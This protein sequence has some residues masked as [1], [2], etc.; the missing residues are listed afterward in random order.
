MADGRGREAILELHNAA[1][2]RPDD[3]DLGLRVAEVS[4]QYGFFG[5]AVDYYKDALALRPEDTQTALKLAQLLLEINPEESKE[6]VDELLE[7]DPRNAHAWLI[8]ARAA[9]IDGEVSPALGYVARARSI[10]PSEPESERI[11]ALAYETRGRLAM[12]RNPLANPSPRVGQSILKAYDRY[13]ALDGEY[14]LL[15]LLG[16]ARTLARLPNSSEQT[17][18]AF[19]EAL[20]EARTIGSPYEKIRVARGAARF[21]D[22]SDDN[23]LAQRAVKQWIATAPYDLDAWQTLIGLDAP[24]ASAH[25]R[26]TYDRLIHMLPDLPE[27]QALYA[28]YLLEEKGYSEAVTYLEKKMDGSETDAGLLIGI[29]QIQN[30]SKRTKDAAQ[31]LQKL[32]T[33]FPNFPAARLARGEQQLLSED[34]DA[35]A[36]TLRAAVREDPTPRAYRLLARAEQMR[37]HLERALAAIKQSNAADNRTNPISLRLKAQ[38]QA[39]LGKHAAAAGT[40]LTLHRRVGLTPGEKLLLARNFYQGGSPGI[41]RKILLE[42][43]ANEGP[44]PRAA[45]EFARRDGHNVVHRPAIRRQLA[46]VL[47]EDPE[48]MEVLESLTE[49]DLADGQI[50]EARRRLDDAVKKRGWIGRI[51]LIRGKLLLRLGEFVAARDD[52]ER[53]S[54]LDPASRDEA[55]D[56]MTTAYLNDTNVPALVTRMETQAKKR[57]LAADRAGLLARLNLAIGNTR[58][59]LELYDQAASEGSDL[60]FVK[61]DLAFLLA[62]QGGDLDR[63]LALAK[64]AVESPSGSVSTIDTLGYVYLKRGEPDVA[65][66]QFRQAVADATPPV[67][68][69]YYH[70]GMALFELGKKD[71]AKK[72][73]E[74]ALALE[75]EFADADAARQLLRELESQNQASKPPPS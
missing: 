60:L 75:P 1:L 43:L 3:A 25:K 42:L 50:E 11:L 53:A 23:E 72:A 29:V 61:N 51:Y 69:Y 64:A 62:Q 49:L 70:L 48:Q 40:L 15:G 4:L 52:A 14:R 9:L 68:D 36:E 8:R 31:T 28:I 66:W 73:I 54:R 56:V 17:R 45:L 6:R 44:R 58:R 46:L 74:E 19:Y 26:R 33:R 13:L 55:Y 47:E 38:I 21:A 63:A 34:Y 59:A 2:L 7:K 12:A 35:A 22:L 65:V 10:D 20:D 18:D 37:G 27:A 57:G 39:E 5:D 24:D 41:G 32:E 67:P 30:R 16:R 71:Q